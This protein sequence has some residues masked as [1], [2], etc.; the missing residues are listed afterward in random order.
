MWLDAGVRWGG[1]GWSAGQGCR[2]WDA[3]LFRLRVWC[4]LLYSTQI[5]AHITFSFFL[6]DLQ[7]E[8][9]TAVSQGDAEELGCG[10][11]SCAVFVRVVLDVAFEV[12][13]VVR[14]EF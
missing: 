11:A 6:A 13:S 2:A 10:G 9:S 5:R 12:I 3:C 8:K 14:L 7:Y 4:L 1:V